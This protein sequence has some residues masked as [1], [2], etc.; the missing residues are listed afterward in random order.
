MYRLVGTSKNITVRNKLENRLAQLEQRSAELAKKNNE[1]TRTEVQQLLACAD[2]YEQDLQKQ[3]DITYD[4]IKHRLDRVFTQI[5]RLLLAT[6]SRELLQDRIT[7]ALTQRER[8]VMQVI[9]KGYT[10]KEAAELFQISQRTVELHRAHLME[11]LGI[12]TVAELVLI[13]VTIGLIDPW[14]HDI[15]H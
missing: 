6:H 2:T 13:A 12:T 9:A 5:G 4:S 1:L 14:P 8:D 3:C 11:K 15:W 7:T 10:N